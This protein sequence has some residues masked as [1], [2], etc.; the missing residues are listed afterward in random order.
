MEN[1][2]K[3]A[4]KQKYFNLYTYHS[5]KGSSNTFITRT[6]KS[7]AR[8]IKYLNKTEYKQTKANEND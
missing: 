7:N 8:A 6:N 2:N 4:A 1:H 5:I 3:F